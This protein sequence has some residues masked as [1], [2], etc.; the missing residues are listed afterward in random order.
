MHDPGGMAANK[1]PGERVP[2]SGLHYLIFGLFQC[3]K[4][5]AIYKLLVLIRKYGQRPAVPAVFINSIFHF[6]VICNLIYSGHKFI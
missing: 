4:I 6:S 3:G 5:A 2:G 1:K